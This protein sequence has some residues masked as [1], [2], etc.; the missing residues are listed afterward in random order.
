MKII[1]QKVWAIVGAATLLAATF[2]LGYITGSKSHKIPTE[3]AN[4][5]TT[6]DM[7]HAFGN[8]KPSAHEPA[9]KEPAAMSLSGL[10]AGLEKK[11]AANP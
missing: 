2:S 9:M 7:E 6:T 10:V 8:V 1:T 4:S 5:H 3:T 11:V